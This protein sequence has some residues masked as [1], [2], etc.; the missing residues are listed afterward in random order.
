VDSPSSRLEDNRRKT[1]EVSMA[2]NA[3]DDEIIYPANVPGLKAAF[4]PHLQ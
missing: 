1:K 3:Q 2:Q 4:Y